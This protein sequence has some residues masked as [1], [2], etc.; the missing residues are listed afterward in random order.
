MEYLLA[1]LISVNYSDSDAIDHEARAY[2]A[3][4]TCTITTEEIPNPFKE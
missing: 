3:V 2:C 4:H 1:L